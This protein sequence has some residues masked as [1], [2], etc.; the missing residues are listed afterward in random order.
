LFLIY[1]VLFTAFGLFVQRML[2]QIFAGDHPHVAERFDEVI[3]A[4]PRR[5]LSTMVVSRW[6]RLDLLAN[7]VGSAESELSEHISELTA[8]QYVHTKT[9]A[10]DSGPWVCLSNAGY[11]EYIGHICALES[12]AAAL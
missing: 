11:A 9:D 12:A 6:L 7:T 1:F 8:A 4:R 2:R 5:M 10:N 3:A